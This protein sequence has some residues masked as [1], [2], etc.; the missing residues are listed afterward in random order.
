LPPCP[1][2]R[3]G[4]RSARRWASEDD[5]H[6][7]MPASHRGLGGGIVAVMP[8]RPEPAPGPPVT[9]V[10]LNRWACRSPSEEAYGAGAEPSRRRPSRANLIRRAPLNQLFP[11]VPHQA[12]QAGSSRAGGAPGLRQLRHPQDRHHPAVAGRPP[13]VPPALRPDQLV[14]AQSGR[15]LVRRTH[16]QAAP[17]RRAHQRPRPGGR[18]PRLDRDLEQGPQA[19]CV[20]PRPPMR[21]SAPSHG[22]VNEPPAQDTRSWHELGVGVIVHVVSEAPTIVS[23]PWPTT[24]HLTGQ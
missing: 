16:H 2:G 8:P 14:L 23:P 17:A 3:G 12:R 13:A 1:G 20:D 7:P 11:P 5:L 10:Q 19:V 9:R 18:H 4:A 24:G 22:I 15:T 6:E 21:S